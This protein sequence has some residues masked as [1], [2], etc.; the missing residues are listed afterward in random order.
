MGMMKILY[1]TNTLWAGGGIEHITIAKANALAAIDGNVVWIA[2]SR[3]E[4]SSFLALSS[5][6]EG[7]PL[8]IVEAMSCGLPV[9]ATACPCGPK[10]IIIDGINGFLVPVGHKKIMVER[11]CR[12][13]EDSDLRLRMG[14]NALETSKLYCMESIIS[15]WMQLFEE[16]ITERQ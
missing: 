15:R 4:S 9:V 12:L 8:A 13:M 3:L 10:D 6:Y 2:I 14:D 16:L 5:L 1:C 11:I 7:F